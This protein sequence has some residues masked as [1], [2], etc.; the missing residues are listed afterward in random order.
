VVFWLLLQGRL[1]TRGLLRRK[2]MHL[3]S[4]M[5]E[6]CLLQ[7]EERLR[8][9][10]LGC[11]FAKKLLRGHWNP[12]AIMDETTKGSKEN[13][14]EPGSSLCNGDHYNQVMEYM[15]CQKWLALQE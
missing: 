15:E 7:K 6:L 13:Q 11:P 14:A 4:Y 8:H 2:H 3:E 5:C 1:N 10:F 12:S 9:L